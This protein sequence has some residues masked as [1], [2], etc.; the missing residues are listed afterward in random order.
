[1][2][3]YSSD[4]QN[5]TILRDNRKENTDYPHDYVVLP[6]IMKMRCLRL[7]KIHVPMG[8]AIAVSSM[9]IFGIGNRNLPEQT[10]NMR[11][12]SR[13]FQREWNHFR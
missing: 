5:W 4:K 13:Q 3:E 8:G 6:E 11:I 10:N 7:R 1:M 2:L 9:R 12:R